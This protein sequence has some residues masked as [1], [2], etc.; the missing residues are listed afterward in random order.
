MAMEDVGDNPTVQKELEHVLAAT[1]R[2]KEL[3]E[4]IL[5]FS[6]NVDREASPIH[7]HFI[8]REGLKFVRASLP[9][10]IEIEQN[11]NIDSGVV[12]ANSPQIHQVL[13]NLC[14]NAAHAMR[15]TGGTLR[16]ELEPFEVDEEMAASN[17]NLH[18]GPY[19]RLRI[20]DTG[21]GMDESTLERVF[22]PFFTTKEDGEGT[23]LGLSVVHGIVMNHGGEISVQSEPD[24]GTTVTVYL[25]HAPR[26]EELAGDVADVSG[27]ERVLFVDDE[28]EIAKLGKRMLE[29]LGYQVITAANG[30][31][32]MK[33][34]KK[35]PDEIDI[36]VSDQ[37]MPHGTGLSLTERIR[38][39]RNDLP[40]VLMTG[41]SDMITPEKI[42]QLN[43]RGL[44]MKPLA[45]R[46]LGAAIREALDN[47]S[48]T[49][50]K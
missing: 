6:K 44:V 32:A 31:E 12:L 45:G 15:D 25:P 10:T 41:Y 23:G 13:V 7:L 11:V 26:E 16:V 28:P 36:L 38:E 4:Q 14:T 2:A 46:K 20:K 37:T 50:E 17:A 33:I 24:K 22:E 35:S 34:F 47:N 19:A 5:L 9:T 27:S 40:V 49:G 43:I 8:I 21:R 1:Q 29:R 18:A 42:E 3:V 30:R 48:T 39:V